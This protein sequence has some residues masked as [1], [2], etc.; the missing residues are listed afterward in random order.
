MRSH[1]NIG[2]CSKG[3]ENSND[4]NAQR[5]I[6]K[7]R[8]RSN[9]FEGNSRGGELLKVTL[10]CFLSYVCMQMFFDVLL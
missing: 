4:E 8:Y 2:R 3:F 5:K 7:V 10:M 1:R 9:I 6:E